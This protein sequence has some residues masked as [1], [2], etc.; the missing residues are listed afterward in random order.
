MN[1]LHDWVSLALFCGIAILFLQRSVGPK[2]PGDSMIR[3]LPAAIGCVAGD[4]LGNE[5]WPVAGWAVL[6]LTV[7]Y[8]WRVLL[9]GPARG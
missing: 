1:T 9:R 6:A 5:G 2:L 4:L 3:Y 7:A 8:S